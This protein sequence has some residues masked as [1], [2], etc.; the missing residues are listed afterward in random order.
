[1]SLHDMYE[2]CDT[3]YEIRQR[4]VLLFQVAFPL[5][6]ICSVIG[7]PDTG[8][9]REVLCSPRGHTGVFVL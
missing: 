6:L 1:M 2:P 4:S 7:E 8:V 5:A 3:L 9:T